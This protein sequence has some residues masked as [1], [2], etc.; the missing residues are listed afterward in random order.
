MYE[1]YE[2]AAGIDGRLAAD[3]EGRTMMTAELARRIAEIRSCAKIEE[4]RIVALD[5][6]G[7]RALVMLVPR[8]CAGVSTEGD[9]QQSDEPFFMMI[10][11][12][13]LVRDHALH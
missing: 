7:S 9:W 11:P 2:R 1:E 6:R 13:A 3:L 5:D 8:T 4:L 12:A 10:D